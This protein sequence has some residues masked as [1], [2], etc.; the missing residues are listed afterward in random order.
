MGS[1]DLYTP[2]FYYKE[3]KDYILFDLAEWQNGFAF[4][5]KDFSDRGIPI[6]KIAELKNGITSNTNF[7]NGIFE[8]KYYLKRKDL[9]FS[10][11]GSPD[12]SIDVFWFNME[13]GWLN[14]HIFKLYTKEEII[15]KEY[16]YYLLKYLKPYLICIAKNKQTTGLGHVTIEDLKKIKV[17]LPPLYNIVSFN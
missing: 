3:W 14:Q 12:T 7:T 1:N 5:K 2:F 15:T 9:L 13:K 10:W 11:S 16:L 6:I 8:E 4:K 17:K